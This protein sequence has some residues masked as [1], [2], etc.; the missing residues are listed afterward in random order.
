MELYEHDPGPV[1]L[2]PIVSD[3]EQVGG[4]AFA[5][6][7]SHQWI[8]EFST[9]LSSLALA[10]YFYL[11]SREND[12]RH[13]AST[14]IERALA[15]LSTAMWRLD[16]ADDT[17]AIDEHLISLADALRIDGLMVHTRDEG[18]LTETNAW[19]REGFELP[20]AAQVDRINAG[21]EDL[22]IDGRLT[23]EPEQQDSAGESLKASDCHGL[24]I[25]IGSVDDVIGAITLIRGEGAIGDHREFSINRLARTLRD[26]LRRIQL[27]SDLNRQRE[28]E[29]LRAFAGSTLL[30]TSESEGDAS[31][32]IESVLARVAETYVCDQVLWGNRGR[33]SP[34]DRG[35]SYRAKTGEFSPMPMSRFGIDHWIHDED[36]IAVLRLDYPTMRL[37]GIDPREYPDT[38]VTVAR[39]QLDGE[40][41][42]GLALI[43]HETRGYTADELVG[44][45]A[46]SNLIHH[47]E[48]R[49]DASSL[50][51]LHHRYDELRITIANEL[52]GHPG[53]S[54]DEMSECA[55]AAIGDAFGADSVVFRRGEGDIL[56]WV[57]PEGRR[58]AE[59]I[60]RTGAGQAMAH[61]AL[62][63][64][65]SGRV[66][67]MRMADISSDVRVQLQD[68]RVDEIEIIGGVVSGSGE[69][70]TISAFRFSESGW[71]AL[72]HS[73]LIDVGTQLQRTAAA[74]A[75]RDLAAHHQILD[76]LVARC[77]AALIQQSD[78]HQ[79]IEVVLKDVMDT[80]GAAGAAWL[81]ADHDHLRVDV[82][83]AV[84]PNGGTVAVPT[85]TFDQDLW[86]QM[87]AATPTTRFC[88]ID[89][90]PL[91]TL[92]E[93]T[94]GVRGHRGWS[95]RCRSRGDRSQYSTCSWSRTPKDPP[96]PP[97]SAP[98]DT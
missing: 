38:I 96:W 34:L 92:R 37:L 21:W 56:M 1:L 84:R 87:W 93:L 9:A 60:Y 10:M 57:S 20:T 13:E 88:N 75:A 42:G 47:F 18:S 81:V 44:L 94:P 40:T 22:N 83:H 85:L 4:L 64:S 69:P 29:R 59:A 25:S 3:G 14:A 91:R 24:V 23:W 82:T 8:S 98:S 48:A 43:T 90:E 77:V 76:E 33:G 31:A 5:V 50:A 12:L 7:A 89:E 80:L 54:L 65:R 46:V 35:W 6:P 70:A 62:T 41:L 72:E 32:A 79:A 63:H 26:F 15:K 11:A 55:L 78:A 45:G 17:S 58:M 39:N 51:A 86:D 68:L 74:I 66:T 16:S 19:V 2:Y 53:E 67:P 71:G 97:R 61:E 73:T 27:E 30:P 36:S 52:I 49:V 28:L 95:R